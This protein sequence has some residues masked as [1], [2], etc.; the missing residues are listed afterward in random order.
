LKKKLHILFLCG[1][2]PS[3]VL[4]TNGDFIQRHAEAVS[5]EHKTSVLHVISTKEIKSK[6]DFKEINGVSTYIGYVKETTNPVLKHFLF[7][8]IYKQILKKIEEFDL[9]HL[10][11]VYPFGIA[12]LHLKVIKKKPFIISEHWTG[13]HLPQSKEIGFIQKIISKQI[14]KKASFICPVSNHL[15]NAMEQFGLKGTYKTVPN[16]VDTNLF[17][18]QKKEKNTFTIV[19]I[20][21][22]LDPH[23]NISGML[24]TAK[25]LEKRIGSFTWKFIGGSSNE[26]SSLINELHF[27]SAK[28]EFI[29]HIPQQE[30]VKELQQA[31]VF[32]LF[33]NYENLPC[34]ILE[35]FSCGIPVIATN[36]GGINEYFPKS[37]GKLIAKGNESE[38]LDALLCSHQNDDDNSAKMHLFA[39]EYFSKKAIANL[40]S[41]TYYKSLST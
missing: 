37:F 28:I 19:H 8:K 10:N 40:F 9:V 38:L 41:E 20:S 39:K 5:L 17:K 23:K 1:W 32:V 13:Y 30:L 36:V 22:L 14:S 11:E 27:S 34:V 25:E 15:K 18:P 3:K 7:W 35:S 26:F 29:N 2:Y 33:S 16:V 6:I 21:S 24:R 4:P 31:D 12:A